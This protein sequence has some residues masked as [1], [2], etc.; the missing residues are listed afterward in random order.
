MMY[1]VVKA[2]LSGVIIM[3]VSE[4]ARRSPAVGALVAS[5]PLVSV[6]AIIWLWRDTGDTARIADHAEATF[7]YVLPS[8][9]MFLVFPFMLRQGLGFWPSLGAGCLLTIALYGLTILVAARFGVRL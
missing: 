3:A 2:L 5:L 6:L 1:L 9:P 7:W 8:L 4:I